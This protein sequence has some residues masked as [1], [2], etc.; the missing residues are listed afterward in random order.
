M[1]FPFLI[2]YIRS[3][4]RNSPLILKDK[5]DK[6]LPHFSKANHIS[7]L[8]SY[9]VYISTMYLHLGKVFNV[10]RI[11]ISFLAMVVLFSEHVVY[12][13]YVFLEICFIATSLCVSLL[14]ANHTIPHPPLLIRNI[15]YI[16]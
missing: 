16:I 1:N 8:S 7:L 6:H 12:C 13:G 11:L 5:L 10:E 4:L 15:I 2:E 9:V 3:V 14:N